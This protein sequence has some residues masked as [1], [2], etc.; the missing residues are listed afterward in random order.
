[1]TRRYVVV[2]HTGGVNYEVIAEFR[3]AIDAIR[4]ARRHYLRHRPA[5]LQAASVGG[6]TFYDYPILPA[7]GRL[8]DV[9]GY[10]LEEDR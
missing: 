4:A 10:L 6:G 8:A 9:R 2:R 1:M 5:W 3:R 7:S